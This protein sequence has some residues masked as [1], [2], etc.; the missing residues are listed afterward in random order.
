MMIIEN[1]SLRIKGN[2]LSYVYD[3]VLD[4]GCFWGNNQDAGAHSEVCLTSRNEECN[5]GASHGQI[6]KCAKKWWFPS[7]T[8]GALY[9]RN[10]GFLRQTQCNK[11]RPSL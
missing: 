3:C 1:K 7:P 9:D 11:V 5:R 6:K 2:P 4:Y 8:P 10:A